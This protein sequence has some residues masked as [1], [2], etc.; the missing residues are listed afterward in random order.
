MAS[1]INIKNS[2]QEPT[3][4]YQNYNSSQILIFKGY[5]KVRESLYIQVIIWA[6]TI[7][8]QI[9]TKAILDLS[10]KVPARYEKQKCPQPHIPN[11]HPKR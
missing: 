6:N 5:L 8:S 4:A 10:M 3:H 2:S 1:T 9:N 11:W 7:P